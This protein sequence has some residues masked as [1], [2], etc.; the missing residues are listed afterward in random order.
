VE[1]EE[2]HRINRRPTAVRIAL[3]H[4]GADEGKVE[5]CIEMSVEVVGWDEPF[6]GDDSRPVEIAMFRWA[7]HGSTSA[8]ATA[9]RG[10]IV[11]RCYPRFFTG[12]VPL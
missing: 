8:A 7:K 12:P 5:R 4:P 1:A 6:E 11:T 3:G 10:I 9:N 2:D